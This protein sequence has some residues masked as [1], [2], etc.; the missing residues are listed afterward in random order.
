MCIAAYSI[1]GNPIPNDDILKTCFRNN[2]D[3]AGFCFNTDN[4]QVQIY[5]L[6]SGASGTELSS[7]DIIIGSDQVDAQ[8]PT[9]YTIFTLAKSSGYPTNIIYKTNDDKTSVDSILTKEQVDTFIILGYE[10]HENASYYYVFV[11][12]KFGWIKKSDNATTADT[13]SK[14]EI[15]DTKVSDKVSYNAKFSSLGNVYI[16]N[17]F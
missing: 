16:Y 17:L 2:S 9:T 15:V 7:T 3:G 11:N 4:N 5:Q 1:K 6:I 10:G 14:I 13:D 8:V 12:G